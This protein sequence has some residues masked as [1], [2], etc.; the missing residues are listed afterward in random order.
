MYR[1]LLF[2]MKG[3]LLHITP[4]KQQAHILMRWIGCQ[5]FIYNAKV[6]DD[7]YFRT[8]ARK[9]LQLV[10]QYAPIDQTYS[11][12][13]AQAPFLKGVPSQILRNGAVRWRD[14]YSRFFARLGGRPKIKQRHGRQSMLV[15]TLPRSVPVVER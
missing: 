11:Q 1:I 12:Y 3:Q 13:K 8:F 9:S 14:A 5:R 10:G 7:R 2:S 4:S 6:Q 15:T